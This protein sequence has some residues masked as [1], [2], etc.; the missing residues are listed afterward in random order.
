M[1]RQTALI[2]FLLGISLFL[3]AQ[4]VIKM[5]DYE[6]RSSGICS[7]TKIER[8]KEAT[9]I[10]VLC[11]FVPH[12]WVKFD[13][14]THV[15]DT[16]T[17][18]RYDP[19]AIEG[20]EFGKETYLPDSGDTTLVFVY[21][22]FDKKM[23]KFD[24][25]EEGSD[26]AAIYGVSLNKPGKRAKATSEENLFGNWPGMEELLAEK[27]DSD[28]DP[29]FFKSD[30]AHIRG[31]IK[32]YDPRAGFKTGIIYTENMLSRE[33]YPTV[34]TIHPDGR[35]EADFP[36]NHPSQSN[37]YMKENRIPFYIEP[38]ETLFVHLDW[39]D[40]LQ[41][42]RFRNRRGSFSHTQYAGASAQVNKELS[43]IRIKESDFYNNYN[44]IVETVAPADFKQQQLRVYQETCDSLS[45]QLAQQP[46]SLKTQKLMKNLIAM[47]MA[48]IFFDYEDRRSYKARQDTTN[49][50]MKIPLP[51]DYYDFLQLI[52]WQDESLPASDKFST[53]INR[54]EYMDPFMQRLIILTPTKSFWEYAK[55]HKKGLQPK[56][57]DLINSLLSFSNGSSEK[58]KISNDEHAKISALADDFKQKYPDL[59]Q[60][61][62]SLYL[63]PLQKK[64]KQDQPNLF[65]NYTILYMDPLQKELN[66]L[67]DTWAF[68]DSV[69]QYKLHLPAGN[70]FDI[71]KVRALSYEFGLMERDDALSYI[72]KLKEGISDPFLQQ[73][74]IRLFEKL[75]PSTG[76]QTYK[77]PEGKATDI[78]RKIADPHKGKYVLVD[79]WATSCGPCRGGIENMRP[80]R[81]KYK[82]SPDFTFVYIT[83]TGSSPEGAYNKFVGEN[84][85]GENL[86]RLPEDEYNYLRQLFKFN[87]IPRYVLLNRD[88]DVVD[89]DFPAHNL[90]YELSK[91]FTK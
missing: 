42:D 10:H 84:A 82:D 44:K 19:I 18:K 69:R 90:V 78:F 17:G 34:I 39:E 79:F 66:R 36:L 71:T 75:F 85:M 86:H 29:T 83:D 45:H 91:I 38:G 27:Q 28:F 3:S 70:T 62:D 41:R 74:G 54:F 64:F 23:K 35:F 12:W 63:E 30:T 72:T 48:T 46:F 2:T 5:P 37:F 58:A 50:V 67:L 55:E 56:E 26:G 21:P 40:F 52:N 24:W 7:I 65:K 20:T 47:E 81:E 89:D 15:I 88:G 68:K 33:D 53:F 22:P 31:Y 76:K 49:Q 77:L 59:Y 80:I 14:N 11:Q 4:R 87:G 8:Q 16:E 73:E 61:Y 43:Q 1:K 25:Q 6:F 32:G 13:Q 60:D 57:L 9:R 51:A